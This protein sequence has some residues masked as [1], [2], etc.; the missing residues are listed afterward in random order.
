[1]EDENLR[2]RIGTSLVS[3]VLTVYD[4]CIQNIIMSG[5][6]KSKA[7]PY[8]RCSSPLSFVWGKGGD[9][10]YSWDSATQIHVN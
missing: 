5:K 8:N 2:G 7:R 3:I 1:M 9:T 6:N 10:K 4:H